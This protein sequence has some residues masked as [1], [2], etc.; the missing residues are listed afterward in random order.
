MAVISLS[1]S[2]PL[3]PRHAMNLPSLPSEVLNITASYPSWQHFH[4]ITPPWSSKPHHPTMP[5]LPPITSLQR[6]YHYRDTA[7]PPLATLH[8]HPQPHVTPVLVHSL[9]ASRRPSS[10]SANS[11]WG[12]K[13]PTP[14][15][16]NAPSEEHVASWFSDSRSRSSQY[17][18]ENT[19][20]M[21]CYLWFSQSSNLSPVNTSPSQ[22][23]IPFNPKTARLQ[24]SVSSVFVHFMQ[25][26]L[27]TTQLSQ[28]VIVLSLHY[29]Y[30]LKERNSGTI[31]HPGSEFRVAVAALM[32]A[33]KFVDDNTYTNKTWSEVSGIE[34][35]EINKMEREFLAGIDF[36][37]YVD[38][39]TYV[40]WVG[41]LEGLVM[42]KERGSR[43]WRRSRQTPRAATVTRPV[44]PLTVPSK[45]RT[46]SARA[47]SSSP[48]HLSRSSGSPHYLMNSN[49][50][51]SPEITIEVES[52]LRS[53]GKRSA[54]DAFSPTSAAFDVE[55]PAKRPIS[56]VV[57]IPQS[58]AASIHTPSPLDSLQSFSKLS[59][60]SSP[61]LSQC[62]DGAAVVASA[63]HLP[64]Q[65]LIASYRLDPTKPRPVPKHLF[66]YSLAGSPMA[67]D[68]RSRK[69]LLRYHQPPESSAPSYYAYPPP[70]VPY[71]IQSASASPHHFSVTLPPVLPSNTLVSWSRNAAGAVVSHDP[72]YTRGEDVHESLPGLREATNGSVPLA[73]FANAGP[74]GVHYHYPTPAYSPDYHWRRGRR[75]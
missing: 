12:Q 39:E 43:Q 42:A 64:P 26:L 32:M 70:P 44:A 24:F 62:N 13:P 71:A 41:L 19:C 15:P 48:V 28:S 4:T 9:D 58:T 66:F 69:G 2:L 11:A 17:T 18:A 50:Q 36:N 72:S 74:P 7:L 49:P 46:W 65:T 5:P 63:R 31:A 55:R 33:N 22:P 53:R 29:V 54:F 47:R 73:P 34:L 20:E 23:L 27:Q 61:A 60:G 16:D 52:P 68:S 25:K 3:P 21:I 40:R 51:Y 14:P 38:K 1:S 59:L 75:L 67:D 30:R 6:Q 56:L 57:E 8:P 45:G 35:M 10:Y 37:L